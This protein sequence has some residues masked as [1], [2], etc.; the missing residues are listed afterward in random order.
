MS[1]SA[2]RVS[3]PVLA[4]ALR[5][6]QWS[7]NLLVFVPVLASHRLDEM[8]L[9]VNGGLAFVTFCLVASSV[10]LVND[11][12]DVDDDRRHPSKRYRPIASG[13]LSI[14]AARVLAVALL[15]AGVG[16]AH[17]LL[18]V[19]YLV[20]LVAY[21]A[22]TLAYSLWIKRIVM[23]DVVTLAML[24]TI[25][26]I[27]GALA[28]FQVVTFWLLAFCVFIFLSLAF[29]KRYTELKLSSA[30][31]AQPTPTYGR[32][33]VQADFELLASLGCAAGYISVLVLALYIND[34]SSAAL[35]RS[36]QW[37]WPACLLLLAW[38]SRVWLIAHRGQ[39][40][41]D[42]IVFALRDNASRLIGAA[43]VVVFVV[44]S[45]WR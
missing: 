37:L 21:Y 2:T 36:Q 34:A 41:D 22:L 3:I 40:H 1:A 18:P 31:E 19:E 44:A 4:R 33:Y 32:G 29:L 30:E 25:R 35:Y 5:V 16:L 6:H 10:Y 28:T 39:M 43:V 12:I 20:A 8:T 15:V 26:V 42:P 23:I 24:Y 38:L 13:T 27:A 7:K 11:I 9:L 17:L 45:V 14:R